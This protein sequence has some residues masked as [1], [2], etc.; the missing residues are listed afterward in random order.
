[1]VPAG[2]NKHGVARAIESQFDVIVTKVNI[3]N[4][5]GKTK[6]TVSITG[7]RM[8]SKLGKRS[9]LKK[10]YVTLAEGNQLPFFTAIEEEAAKEKAAQEKIDKAAK[11]EAQKA[12]PRR[13]FSR[14]RK[15]EGV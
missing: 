12:A 2:L 15:E 4:I 6:R 10:A 9:D 5:R 13:R 14:R 1:M 7:K 3:L 11:K 8:Q